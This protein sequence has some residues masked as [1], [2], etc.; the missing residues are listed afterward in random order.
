MA[1][2]RGTIKVVNQYNGSNGGDAPVG[3]VIIADF[4]TF[5]YSTVTGSANQLGNPVSGYLI[6]SHNGTI[7]FSVSLK[8]TASEA[9]TLDASSQMFFINTKNPNNVGY[10]TFYI[11]DVEG[12]KIENDFNV[13]TISPK[14]EKTIYF[15][16]AI[17]IIDSAHFTPKTLATSGNSGTN[18]GNGNNNNGNGDSKVDP[19]AYPLNLALIG[20]IGGKPFGQNIPFVTVYISN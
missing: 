19:G 11:V 10:L 1:S 3:S 15:A 17:P 9:I 4:S 6:N 2:P 18:N 16:S 12:N 14:E 5:N 13:I 8:N 7:A 20:S